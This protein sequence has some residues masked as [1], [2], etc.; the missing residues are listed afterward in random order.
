[1]DNN[2]Q[3]KK[4]Y[5]VVFERA[6]CIGAG[7]CVSMYSRRWVMNT[8][9]D[10]ADLIG[11]RKEENGTFVVEF[12]LEELEDFK[13]SAVVCPVNVIHIYDLETGEKLI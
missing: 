8:Q 1:M 11:G 2:S 4:K 10:K 7:S 13:A 9:D 6:N 3:K 5:K 12:T